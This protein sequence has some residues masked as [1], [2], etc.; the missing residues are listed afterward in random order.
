MER[1]EIPYPGLDRPSLRTLK[2]RR[3]TFCSNVLRPCISPRIALGQTRKPRQAG[4]QDSRR[5]RTGAV[6]RRPPRY[7]ETAIVAVICNSNEVL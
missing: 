3:K 2:S 1:Q 6:P 4:P 7:A 5:Y